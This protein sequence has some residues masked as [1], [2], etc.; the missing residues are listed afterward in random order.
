MQNVITDAVFAIIAGSDTTA[1]AL[2][3]LFF[4]LMCNDKIYT[5]LQDEIDRVY[6]AGSDALDASKHTELPF[7]NACMCVLLLYIAELIFASKQSLLFIEMRLSGCILRFLPI[8][9][10]ECLLVEPA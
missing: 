10:V 3:S 8:D 6:P 2:V 4:H 7:L 1:S 9:L 5:R